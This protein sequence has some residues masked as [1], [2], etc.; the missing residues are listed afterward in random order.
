MIRYNSNGK[1]KKKKKLELDCP[2]EG[3]C[4]CPLGYY[5]TG[6]DCEGPF[7]DFILILFFYSL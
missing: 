5:W 2:V 4:S 6:E 3:N 1:K 7:F